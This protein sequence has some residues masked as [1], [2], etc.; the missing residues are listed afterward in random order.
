MKHKRQK[1]KAATCS[2]LSFP[3]KES[4]R[5]TM[6]IAAQQRGENPKKLRVYLCPLCHQ[7]H[8]TS[9]QRSEI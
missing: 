2:K 6:E 5:R 9:K 1:K 3:S 4:A 8:Y 7:F